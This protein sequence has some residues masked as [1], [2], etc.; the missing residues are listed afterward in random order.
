MI[1]DNLVFYSDKELKSMIREW[2]NYWEAIE[3]GQEAYY[4]HPYVTVGF[5]YD[6]IRRELYRRERVKDMEDF[7]T[8]DSF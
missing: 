4:P 2:E 7:L 5:S 1:G 6:D 3:K 8:G